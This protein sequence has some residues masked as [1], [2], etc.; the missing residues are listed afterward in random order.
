MW[1]ALLRTMPSSLIFTGWRRRRRAGSTARA[2]GS[3]IRR[4]PPASVDD[5][6]AMLE[7]LARG[8]GEPDQSPFAELYEASQPSRVRILHRPLVRSPFKQWMTANE[9][10]VS[11]QAKL[12]DAEDPQWGAIV[13]P[14]PI[15]CAIRRSQPATSQSE[16][17][18]AACFPL[19]ALGHPSDRRLEK[20]AP[21]LSSSYNRFAR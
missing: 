16:S 8:T 2:A 10:N 3:A 15:S 9:Q 4:S 12:R 7:V 11:L 20:S 17:F 5:C 6:F 14:S 18:G 21:R 1:A 19:R 13:K